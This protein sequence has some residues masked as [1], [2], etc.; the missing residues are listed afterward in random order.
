MKKLRL[1]SNTAAAETFFAG[2]FSN[3][4]EAAAEEGWYKLAETGKFPHL[5]GMQVV[6]ERT[7]SNIVANY[8]SLLGKMGRRFLGVPIFIG[9]PD[10]PQMRGNTGHTDTKAYGWVQDLKVMSNELWVKPK[11]SEEGQKLISNAH[12]RFFSASWFANPLGAGNFEPTRLRSIGLTNHPNI[13]GEALANEQHHTMK[14]PQ[15]IKTL[16]AK[17]GFSN[18][19][20]VALEGES[21]TGAP[22]EAQILAKADAYILASNEATTLRGSNATLTADL[23]TAKQQLKDSQT[24]ATQH[25]TAFANER[26]SHAKLLVA[27]GIRDGKIPPTQSGDWETQFSNSFD[28]TVTK[29]ASA[30]VLLPVAGRKHAEDKGTETG[31]KKADQIAQFSNENL[32]KC[33]NNW[34]LAFAKTRREHPELFSTEE[35]KK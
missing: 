31:T 26:R 25:E 15:W 16:L 35:A 10:D 6:T 18:E 28:T 17:L 30:P 22:T 9:H 3:A 5:G 12:Y 7:L 11:W 14:L 24:T 23:A 19:Q 2:F 1:F 32:P 33:N 27:S 21:Q 13:P 4:I 29:L 8:K 20:I 34:D